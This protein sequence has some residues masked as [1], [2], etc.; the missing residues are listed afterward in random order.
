[1]DDNARKDINEF[2]RSQVAEL[3]GQD[4]PKSDDPMVFTAVAVPTGGSF[5]DSAGG[6]LDSVLE[7]LNRFSWFIPDRIETPIRAVIATVKA[8]VLPLVCGTAVK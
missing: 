1:M 7:I 3:E 2:Y 8:K 6:V 4:K 5:C